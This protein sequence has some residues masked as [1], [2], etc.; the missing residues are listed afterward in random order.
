MAGVFTAGLALFSCRSRKAGT[1]GDA[2]SRRIGLCNGLCRL[3]V[4]HGTCHAADPHLTAKRLKVAAC[5]PTAVTILYGPL[6]TLNEPLASFLSASRPLTSR[7]VSHDLP[8][9]NQPVRRE[10]DA[11]VL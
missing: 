9:G 2:G 11:S 3:S 4:G 1:P 7:A 10:G 6:A 5:Q 8:P